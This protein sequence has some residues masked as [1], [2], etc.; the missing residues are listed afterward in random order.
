MFKKTLISICM[1]IALCT[2]VCAYAEQE[3]IES[4]KLADGTVLTD[5]KE[6]IHFDEEQIPLKETSVDMHFDEISERLSKKINLKKPE[7]FVHLMKGNSRVVYNNVSDYTNFICTNDFDEE[8]LKTI[9]RILENGT[10][11]QSLIQ[12]YEFW[13]TTDYDFSMVEEICALE[14]KYFSEYW[15][16]SAFNHITNNIHGVLNIDDIN[17]YR[18]LGV[19]NDEILAANVLCRKEGQN[20][21]A[22]LDGVVNGAD[23]ET[24]ALAIYGAETLPEGKDMYWRVIELSKSVAP[25]SYKNS[26]TAKLAAVDT[27]VAVTAFVHG[28]IDEET[29][30][31]KIIEPEINYEEDYA[32]LMRSRLPISVQRVLLNK[33]YTPSEIEQ[34]SKAGGWDIAETIK[35]VREAQSK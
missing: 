10:T 9:N 22:I 23:I 3:E 24:Q 18:D 20:I 21:F 16:E 19:S 25:V 8:Q 12:V 30:R 32:Y 2:S 33:G 29:E 26:P 1:L 35:Q 11:I 7:E 13:L 6:E 27:K 14:D 15:Y 5:V 31:L 17:Y 28:K 34:A 4:L